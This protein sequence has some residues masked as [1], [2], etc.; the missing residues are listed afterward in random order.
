MKCLN[1]VQRLQYENERAQETISNLRK[2]KEKRQEMQRQKDEERRQKA[3]WKRQLRES[4][5]R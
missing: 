4:L 2:Q 3:E 1:R 5:E